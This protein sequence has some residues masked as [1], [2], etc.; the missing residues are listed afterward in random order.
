MGKYIL[1]GRNK[2]YEWLEI[3]SSFSKILLLPMAWYWLKHGWQIK[4]V[5]TNK[6]AKG[7]AM[8]KRLRLGES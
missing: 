2:N 8:I 4:V 3:S 1:Y 7:T 5:P 6:S